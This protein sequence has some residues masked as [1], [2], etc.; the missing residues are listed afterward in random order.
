MNKWT[1]GLALA[2]G[3]LAANAQALENYDE[4]RSGLLSN[5]QGFRTGILADYDKFLDGI[6]DEYNAFS[7]LQRDKTPKPHKAPQAEPGK[8]DAKPEQP[9]IPPETYQPPV[10]SPAPATPVAPT[11]PASDKDKFLFFGMPMELTHYDLPIRTTLKDA[12]DYAAQWKQLAGSDAPRLAKEVD[13]MTDDFGFNGYLKF[14]LLKDWAKSRFPHVSAQS[15]IALI[16][17]LMLNME[18]D[19]R[20]GIEDAGKALMLIPF[21]QMVYGVPFLTINGEKYYIFGDDEVSVMDGARM[22][23]RTCRLPQDFDFGITPDLS[24]HELKLPMRAKA[25]SFKYGDINLTGEVNENAMSL[26]YDYPQMEMGEYCRSTIQPELREKLEQQLKTQLAGKSEQDAVNALLRFTQKAF[27]Y[28]T[29]DE[30]FGFEKPYFLEEMLYYPTCDCEDRAIF[31]SYFLWNVL[32]RPCQVINY[33]GHEAAAVSLSEPIIGDSYESSG[34]TW[35][36]SD[37]TYINSRTG[38]AMPQFRTTLP[39]IDYTYK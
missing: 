33:P 37:P 15:R 21:T 16:H 27:R 30:T 2:A 26:L 23:I 9:T 35:Y 36:I 20:L 38:Q 1:L 32:E 18:Y 3:S 25:F 5:M 39:T 4:F 28:A 8:D 14:L 17:F 34:T 29:D 6:W 7:P 10:T 12:P 22:Y 11:T 24:L 31:F 13:D 19:V